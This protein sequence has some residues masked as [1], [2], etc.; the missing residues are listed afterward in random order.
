MKRILL[1]SLNN[2]RLRNKVLISFLLFLLLPFLVISIYIVIQFRNVSLDRAYKQAQEKM[3]RTK[4]RITEV[5]SSALSIADRLSVNQEFSAILNRHYQDNREVFLEYHYFTT[6]SDFVSYNPDVSAVRV[7]MDNQTLLNNWEIIPLTQE[8]AEG[9]W[10]IEA[11][12]A[13][14]R[15]IWAGFSDAAKKNRS[16]LSLLRKLVF[17]EYGTEAVIVIDLGSERISSI[18]SQESFETLL[19]DQEGQIL[20]AQEPGLIGKPYTEVSGSFPE[21]GS[22]ESSFNISIDDSNY[23]VLVAEIAFPNAVNSVYIYSLFSLSSIVEEAD[24]VLVLGLRMIIINLVLAFAALYSINS[25]LVRRL[26]R[27]SK[28]MDIVAQ[29]HFHSLLTVDGGDEIGQ[30]AERFNNMVT[31]INSLMDEIHK[32][33]EQKR[34]I[35][36]RQNEIKLKMLASQI[37]PHFLFNSLE[38][39]RMKAHLEKQP[40]IANIV[41]LLGK[42]MRK[43]MDIG[44]NRTSLSDE[45]DIIKSFLEIEK[46]R[47]DKNL[48]YSLDIDPGCLK[49]ELPPLLI[50]PLVENSVIHAVEKTPGVG[51]IT[52]RISKE[53][54]DILVSVQ[55]NGPGIPEKVISD[56][57]EKEEDGRGAH[58]GMRNVHER[59][60][61]TYPGSPGLSISN[62][63]GGGLIVEFRIPGG[64][65]NV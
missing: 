31:N 11:M 10:Y 59:L 28:K 24:R 60:K 26:V 49:T 19:V 40:E 3:I 55:D 36:N 37:N 62:V 47:L 8:Y 41:K 52:V 46:F 42:L 38:A 20:A 58:I 44:G 35:E 45:L 21:V 17:R 51:E 12:E 30:L 64:A 7:Y 14:G 2:I 54:E 48:Q 22:P 34:I 29:G 13:D 1:N 61:L 25:L 39:V 32:S 16:Y 56:F 5:L 4:D 50:Q 18:L 33:N 27:F 6:I 9:P 65:G 43:I 57:I 15:N 23:Y 63:N 53:A